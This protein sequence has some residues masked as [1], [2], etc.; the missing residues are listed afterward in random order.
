MTSHDDLRG[1]I[2]LRI[3]DSIKSCQA[4]VMD[5]FELELRDMPNWRQIRSRLLRCFGDRGLIGR[6]EEILDDELGEVKNV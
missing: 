3:S 5:T 4:G 6:V 2:G 1:R